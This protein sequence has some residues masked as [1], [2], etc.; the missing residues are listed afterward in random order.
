M[1]HY[2]SARPPGQHDNTPHPP[3]SSTQNN[4]KAWLYCVAWIGYIG[5]WYSNVK[6]FLTLNLN[7][8]PLHFYA[9]FHRASSSVQNKFTVCAYR[10][11]RHTIIN[12]AC[13]SQ[14][15]IF[16]YSCTERT[17]QYFFYHMLLTSDEWTFIN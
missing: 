7:I 1:S 12:F 14:V 6:L 13:W 2:F 5:T 10:F 17:V 3:P 16:S 9:R 4:C 15:Q 11:C 8:L